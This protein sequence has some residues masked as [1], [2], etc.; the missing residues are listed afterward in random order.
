MVETEGFNLIDPK[1][2]D[3]LWK[4]SYKIDF[5]DEVIPLND[6]Y[7]A[8]GKDEKDGGISLVDVSGKKVWDAKVKGYPY[9]VT[10]T[11]KGVLY[12]STE[13]ANVL[14]LKNW[15]RPLEKRCQIQIY[16][17]GHLRRARR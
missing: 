6:Q 16:S 12:I 8:V 5:L 3:F 1:T 14:D 9:F 2:E 4:K 10:P 17:S 13:R 7:I 11:S 15:K